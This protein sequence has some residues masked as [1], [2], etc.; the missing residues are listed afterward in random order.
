MFNNIKAKVFAF[1]VISLSTVGSAHA[2]LPTEL[3]DLVTG[4]TADFASWTAILWPVL[5][6]TLGFFVLVKWAKRGVNKVT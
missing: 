5:A 1:F 2:V 3:T 4:L 6:L